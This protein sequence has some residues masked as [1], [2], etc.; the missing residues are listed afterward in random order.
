MFDVVDG[1]DT[2]ADERTQNRRLTLLDG[3]VKR[4]PFVR[5]GGPVSTTF[6]VVRD[7]LRHDEPL[8][9]YKPEHTLPPLWSATATWADL[10][11][12][13][14]VPDWLDLPSGWGNRWSLTYR[15]G[16]HDL[17]ASVASVST[18][19]CLSLTRFA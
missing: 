6:P 17:T 8:K 10:T 11:A 12:Q 14:E 1:G 15:H 19:T 18:A 4:R 7:A 5:P 16:D 9:R 2:D 3:G 13:H